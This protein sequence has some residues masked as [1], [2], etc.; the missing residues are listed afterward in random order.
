VA[1]GYKLEWYGEEIRAQVRAEM[2]RRV[3]ACAILVT[4]R[5][6]ELLSVPGTG[7]RIASR[8]VRLR[9][10]STRLLRKRSTRYGFA[11][12]A[13]G[14]PPRKQTGRLRASVTR[15][16]EG[17]VARVGTNLDYG[18]WLEL[19]TRLVDSRPWL[20]PAFL[21]CLP[22]IHAILTAPIGLS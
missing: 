3:E 6:K 18:R 19:G 16:I 7:Q 2:R 8:K 4:N 1:G 13:P 20:R 10:G 9:G 5:A 15:A 14:E 11:P 22:Q 12:S 17:L 21:A